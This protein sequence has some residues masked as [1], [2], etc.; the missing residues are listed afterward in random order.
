[1]IFTSFKRSLS[2]P[3]EKFS[4]ACYQPTGFNYQELIC[5]APMDP[6]GRAIR[7]RRFFK[8]ENG[9]F[10]PISYYLSIHE[11]REAILQGFHSREEEIKFWMQSLSTRRIATLVCWCPHSASSK[12]Q[13][14]DL[15]SFACHSGI[16]AE[17]I[18]HYRPD[19][20][21]FLDDD[22]FDRLV[23]VWR[24]GSPWQPRLF[25]KNPSPST[26]CLTPCAFYS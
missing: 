19:I 24:H 13:L 17:I 7:T 21:V 10:D 11:Y 23:P 1:V 18:M 16:I 4:I 2:Y 3:G 9:V 20:P 15:G 12:A 25:I 26:N 6:E 8:K 5:L 22:R 14:R